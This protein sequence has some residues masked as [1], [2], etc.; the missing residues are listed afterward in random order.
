MK[1][2]D[3]ILMTP[4]VTV[5]LSLSPC[6]SNRLLFYFISGI[7]EISFNISFA[8]FS[9][10]LQGTGMFQ[11]KAWLNFTKSALIGVRLGEIQTIF[12]FF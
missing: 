6:G 11:S 10:I 7:N 1:P 8:V 5:V 2:G 12:F 4:L 9:K 3:V